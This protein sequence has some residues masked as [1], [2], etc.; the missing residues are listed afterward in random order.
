[1]LV[2]VVVH[3]FPSFVTI[4][5]IGSV[6]PLGIYVISKRVVSEANGEITLL[7]ASSV[8]ETFVTVL[9]ESFVTTEISVPAFILSA[10]IVTFP[11]TGST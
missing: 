7:P 5:V 1:M 11:V 4:E 9:F 10:A 2:S 8:E 3:F 6:C